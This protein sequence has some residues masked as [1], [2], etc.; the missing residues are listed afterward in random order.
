ML[1]AEEEHCIFHQVKPTSGRQLYEETRK[2][3]TL[4]SDDDVARKI[5]NRRISFFPVA[6]IIML[7]LKAPT[8][9]SRR[10][11]TGFFVFLNEPRF[12]ISCGL[13][14]CCGRP[15]QVDQNSR[16]RW[17]SSVVLL[18]ERTFVWVRHPWLLAFIIGLL[19]STTTQKANQETG[20]P[21]LLV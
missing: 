17:V 14:Y 20:S 10:Y 8:S 7:K 4:T 12:S 15:G 5:S 16:G 9:L 13:F 11:R 18:W 21:Q 19:Y 1:G 2:D 6:S 3:W